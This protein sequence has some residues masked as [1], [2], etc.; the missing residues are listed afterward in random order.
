MLLYPAALAR[1]QRLVAVAL[2]Q[3]RRFEP[4]ALPD[5]VEAFF[6]KMVLLIRAGRN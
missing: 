6:V 2:L 1:D 4:R 5:D 3:A